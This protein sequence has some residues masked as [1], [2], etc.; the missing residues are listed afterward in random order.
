MIKMIKSLGFTLKETGFLL[1]LDDDKKLDCAP[2]E[3]LFESKMRAIDRQIQDL[4]QMKDKMTTIKCN[5]EG[6]CKKAMGF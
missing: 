3:Q 5:C 6:D 2:V 1:Q 4:Q